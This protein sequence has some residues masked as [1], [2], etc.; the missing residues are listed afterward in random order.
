MDTAQIILSQL[1]GNRFL[2]MTGANCLVADAS[3]GRGALQFK[4]RRGAS[5][6]AT[7]V[8]VTLTDAD[9]YDLDFFKV[10]GLDCRPLQSFAGLYADAL[11]PTFTAATGLDTRL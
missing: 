10:R 8:R 1:G 3:R 11:A 2:A 6:G 7:L 5:N 9:L 4:L